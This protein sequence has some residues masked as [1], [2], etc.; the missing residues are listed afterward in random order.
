MELNRCSMA[1]HVERLHQ[2][3]LHNTLDTKARPTR[4]RARVITTIDL[5]TNL[6]GKSTSRAR[7]KTQQIGCFESWGELSPFVEE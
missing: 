7:D 4:P 1:L 3:E 6:N 5:P 2:D